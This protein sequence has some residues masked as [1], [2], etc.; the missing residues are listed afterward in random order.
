MLVCDDESGP[1]A[2]SQWRILSACIVGAIEKTNNLCLYRRYL[3]VAKRWQAASAALHGVCSCRR[4]PTLKSCSASSP[5]HMRLH[6]IARPRRTTPWPAGGFVHKEFA[7]VFDKKSSYTCSNCMSFDESSPAAAAA[8]I[9]AC[10]VGIMNQT[11]KD[12]C[13]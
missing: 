12:S 10:N 1:A 9:C 3:L 2:G 11:A 8:M 4:C 5:A 13:C 6:S 7:V